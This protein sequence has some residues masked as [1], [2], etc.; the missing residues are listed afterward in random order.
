M[1]L[2]AATPTSP[3]KYSPIRR[4]S[5][6]HLGV[7]NHVPPQQIAMPMSMSKKYSRCRSSWHSE[8]TYWLHR[9]DVVN[10]LALRLP[11][12]AHQIL[13]GAHGVSSGPPWLASG[14][15]FFSAT[16]CL[17][18]RSKR[19]QFRIH[20]RPAL[21][22]TGQGCQCSSYLNVTLTRPTTHRKIGTWSCVTGASTPLPP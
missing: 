6:L 15:Q 3:S 11:C 8:F 21:L 9:P 7:L 2:I 19:W 12:P 20:Q 22:S 10:T 5:H 14:E 13:H 17:C 18:A 4:H 1:D 16:K